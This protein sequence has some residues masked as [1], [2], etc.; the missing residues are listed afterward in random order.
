MTLQKRIK[1]LQAL[2]L[3]EWEK[4]FLVSILHRKTLTGRQ[5]E[6]LDRI[7]NAKSK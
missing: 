2:P 5:R 1:N 3:S 4:Q 7:F 6:T